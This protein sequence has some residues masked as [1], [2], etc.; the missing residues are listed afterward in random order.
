MFHPTD[1]PWMSTC[2]HCIYFTPDIDKSS[3]DGQCRRYPSVI[4]KNIDSYCGEFQ[5][6]P[7]EG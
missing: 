7:E 1:L 6:P 5:F 2:K 3:D 4:W